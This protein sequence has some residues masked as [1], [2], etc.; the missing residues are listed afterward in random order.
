MP[1]TVT[2]LE[3][4][5][6]YL[7]TPRIFKD[8]RGYFFETFKESDLKAGGLDLRFVQENHSASSK[9]VLRGLHYQRAPKAQGKLVRCVVGSILDVVVD[10]RED[11]PTCGQHLSVELSAENRQQLYVAPGFAHGFCVLS[12]YAEITYLVTNEYSPKDEGGV[13]WN[14]PALNIT[15]PLAEPLVSEKDQVLPA[16]QPLARGQY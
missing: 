11:S 7:V 6:I 1:V 5:G 12:D 10:V 15:W 16:F 3:L 8:S 4:E 14:D 13:I 2:P 9:G